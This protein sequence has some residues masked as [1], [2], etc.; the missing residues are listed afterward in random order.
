MPNVISEGQ[1]EKAAVVLFH[2]F[3]LVIREAYFR[4]RGGDRFEICPQIIH[5]GVF[6]QPEA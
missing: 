6:Q 3:G 2:P 4:K 5:A 1:I